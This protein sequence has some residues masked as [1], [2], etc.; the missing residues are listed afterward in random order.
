M[1]VFCMAHALTLR[2]SCSLFHSFNTKDNLSIENLRHDSCANRAATLAER[3]A[4][5]LLQGDGG[6]ELKHGG[7]VVTG[8]DHLGASGRVM[9]P[10]ISA[11]RM[12]NWGR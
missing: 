10:V 6:D 9:V 12:K 5:A 4:Q 1:G 11:V 3:E 2:R 7:D 8:H